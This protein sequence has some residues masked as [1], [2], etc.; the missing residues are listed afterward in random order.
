MTDLGNLHYSLGVK[1][2]RTA[3]GLLLSQA[4]YTIDLL[5]RA[6]MTGCKRVLHQPFVGLNSPLPMGLHYPIHMSIDNLLVPSN[7]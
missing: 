6:G 7:I 3:N 1:A 2:N 5:K 4:R